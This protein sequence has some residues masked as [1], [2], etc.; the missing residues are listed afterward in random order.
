MMRDVKHQILHQLRQHLY[1]PI[2]FD[3]EW[4]Y[5]WYL[6]DCQYKLDHQ[7]DNELLQQ[8]QELFRIWAGKSKKF[9]ILTNMIQNI[10]IQQT[11]TNIHQT[12]KK[13]F[14]HCLLHIYRIK[15]M[16]E[17]TW[18]SINA[19]EK[20]NKET[21]SPVRFMKREMNRYSRYHLNNL[22]AKYWNH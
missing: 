17:L 19:L 8:D 1:V 21:F 22:P 14:S 2:G 7:L 11:T 16:K 6:W 10:P 9:E 12:S 13:L 3:N 15:K 5:Q 20:I 18:Y 4:E